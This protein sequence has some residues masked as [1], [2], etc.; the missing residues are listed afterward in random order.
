MIDTT[1]GAS[2]LPPRHRSLAVEHEE[3]E[4]LL[5]KGK[6]AGEVEA[7]NKNKLVYDSANLQSKE[8]ESNLPNI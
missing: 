5:L 7:V 4:R 8:F 6:N 1:T 2:K 3:E